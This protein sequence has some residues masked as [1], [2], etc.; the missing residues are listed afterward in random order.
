MLNSVK[1]FVVGLGL[2]VVLG[3]AGCAQQP[4]SANSSEAIQAADTLQTVEEKAKFLINEANAF[5][6]S[7]KFDDA[8]KT[9]QYV[10]NNLDQDSAEAK[11]LLERAQ[12]ELKKM[13]EQKIDEVKGEM[14]KKLGS[15]GQ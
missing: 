11:S 6:N 5:I 4:K 9:A 14:Q 3:V 13:A 10:L 12:A 7:K 1:M 15:F 2:I 8:I